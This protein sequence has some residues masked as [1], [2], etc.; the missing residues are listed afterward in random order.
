MG[1][2]EEK[3]QGQGN[4][5]SHYLF[6][7]TLEIENHTSLKN[8]KV[9]SY[10]WRG[11]HSAKRIPFLRTES[12]TKAAQELLVLHLQSRARELG[13]NQ[14]FGFPL[15]VL[16]ELQLASYWTK[17]KPKRLNRKAGDLTNLIQGCEDAL[18]RSGVI[19]DD[20]LIVRMY[21]K[22]IP[23]IDGKNRIIL[24]IKKA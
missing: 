20:S 4:K 15:C 12:K 17:G 13:I 18:T 23:S 8:R 2:A 16:W 19:E 24:K 3:I 22:K 21:A 14:P 5:T 10:K 1:D 6:F 7:H 11:K 9:I